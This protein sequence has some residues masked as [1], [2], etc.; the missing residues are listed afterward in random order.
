LNV[1]AAG[2]APEGLADAH[3][4]VL[5]VSIFSFVEQVA[6][7]TDDEKEKQK[8]LLNRADVIVRREQLADGLELI[9]FD[10]QDDDDERWEE[11]EESPDCDPNCDGHECALEEFKVM[12]TQLSV[13]L[14]G[15]VSKGICYNPSSGFTFASILTIGAKMVRGSAR[16][17]EES[18][19]SGN[20]AFKFRPGFFDVSPDDVRSLKFVSNLLG[21]DDSATIKHVQ[22]FDQPLPEGRYG[23]GRSKAGKITM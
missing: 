19:M 11:C 2:A 9:D 17:G 4:S 5:K 14:R 13:A 3:E 16:Q 1:D 8:E 23:A 20:A 15:A 12:M 22:D 18:K 6:A 7:W 10:V 21:L